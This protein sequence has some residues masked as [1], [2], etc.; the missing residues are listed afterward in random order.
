MRPSKQPMNLAGQ[1]VIV[2]II[3]ALVLPL[4]GATF[5][6][7]QIVKEQRLVLI[8]YGND[9]GVHIDR[10]ADHWFRLWA[11][12]SGL[13]HRAV[14]AMDPKPVQKL[15]A[16]AQKVRPIVIKDS[17]GRFGT[18]GG[19]GSNNRERHFWYWWITAAFS[20]IYFGMLR[21]SVLLY[22][23]PILVPLAMAIL[24]TG[25]TLRNLKFH[26]FGGVNPFRYRAGMRM[27]TWSL[28]MAVG[29]LFLPG[30]LPPV[31]VPALVL[32]FFGG[33]AMVMAHRQK[34]V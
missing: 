23:L 32:M 29:A 18:V 24:V 10:R 17:R 2:A 8:W 7:H 14:H 15:A 4:V 19:N 1:L 16:G 30:A 27:A 26:G 31:V 28:P 34:Q 13:M 6:N 3:L 22:W 9:R 12:D 25:S 21:L 11:I 20:L 33:L 5:V